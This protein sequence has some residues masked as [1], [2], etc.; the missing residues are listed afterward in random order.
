MVYLGKRLTIEGVLMLRSRSLRWIASVS[1]VVLLLPG[2]DGSDDAAADTTLAAT[3]TTEATTTTISATTT[4]PPTTT[5]VAT[6]AVDKGLVYHTDE[7]GDWTLDVFYPTGDGPW[8]LVV[9]IPPQ[10]SVDY[11]GAELAERGV[12]AVV[13]DSWTIEG[14]KDPAPHLYGEMDR[15][16]CVVGWAQAHATDYNANPA[17]T[18]VDGYSGGAM[19]A[20]W[21]GLGLAD[22]AMCEHP[23]GTLPVGL[24][25]GE[26]QFLFNHE[27]WDESF[28][29]GD[30]EPMATLDGYFNADRWTVSPDLAVALWSATNPIGG[31]RSI[32]NPPDADS[33][34]WL[35]EAATPVVNDLTA[36]GALDDGRIDWSDNAL[37][38]EHRMRQTGVSVQNATY[39]IGHNYTDEVY[40]LITSVTSAS[41]SP[42]DTTGEADG[43]L[44]GQTILQFDGSSCEIL[45]DRYLKAGLN[46]LIFVDT[47]GEQGDFDMLNLPDGYTV[48]AAFKVWDETHTTAEF[49]ID[50]IHTHFAGGEKRVTYNLSPGT[51]HAV[52]S[53]TLHIGRWQAEDTILVE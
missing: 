15:A 5:A 44:D 38:M 3:T 26:S 45:G 43:A 41:V 18:T 31:T 8:P 47:A 13:A 22:D 23:I 48:D 4:Q 27:R 16:A 21:V 49:V 30:P 42:A 24:V 19:A 2:C 11:V 40:D 50:V 53:T 35:R 20:A 51:W 17:A 9:V 37:L 39:D 33:W 6:T 36:L 10:M 25:A 46:E 52:C 7:E 12:V 1:A 29:S 14:W 34:L 32:E 28:A